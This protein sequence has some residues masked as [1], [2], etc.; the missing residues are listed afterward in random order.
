MSMV[1]TTAI[2]TDLARP[3]V[4]VM[5]ESPVT[6]WTAGIQKLPIIQKIVTS[7]E[8]LKDELK[9]RM[10]Q[11]N[12]EY[13]DIIDMKYGP[14]NEEWVSFTRQFFGAVKKSEKPISDDEHI[15][16]CKKISE[17]LNHTENCR[18]K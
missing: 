9:E 6:E 4:K 5:L 15:G 1:V 2:I 7:S 11:V 14:T 8:L 12:A 13:P 10:A 3:V 16:I 18:K 17:S